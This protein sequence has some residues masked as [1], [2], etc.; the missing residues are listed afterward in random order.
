[1]ERLRLVLIALT[2]G[3]ALTGC[4]ETAQQAAPVIVLPVTTTSDEARAQF[5]SGLY[6]LDMARLID[7]RAYFEKA[8]EIDP[9]FAYA[10]LN[11]ANSANSLEEFTLNLGKAEEAASGVTREEQLLVEIARKGFEADLKGQLA[12]AQDLVEMAPESPRALLTLAGVQSLHNIHEEAR[13][14]IAR[15][16]ELAPTMAAAHMQAGNSYLFSEPRDLNKAEQHMHRAVE[17]A[18]REPIPP[19]LLGDVYRA[20]GQFEKARDAYTE[21]AKYSGD[22]GM[23]YQQRGHVNS[24]LGDYEAARAEYDESIAMARDNQAAIFGVYRAFVHVHAGDPTAA[25][26]ELKGLAA[27]IDNM[28][29][30]EPTGQKIFALGSAITIALHHRMVDEA[31]A[32][33]TDWSALMRAQAEQVGTDE[34]RRNRVSIIAYNEALLAIKQGRFDTAVEKANEIATLVEPDANPRK[35]EPVHEARGTIALEQGNYEEAAEHFRQGNYRNTIYIKYN[36][37][38]A[39]EG[40][41]QTDEA[42]ELYEDIANWGFNTVDLALTRKEAIEKTQK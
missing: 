14:S 39:L 21:A 40:A 23:P 8:T 6:A 20:Q 33:I 3:I 22:D 24:F 36:L 42:M 16:I 31:E 7:A 18:P 28:D 5:M 12:T 29:I 30:P 4:T 34:F 32:L 11:L 41:G 10:Y 27:R 19:D 9:A 26:E 37:A 15:A 35:M 13:Q 2:I 1:M 25:I 17:L 38:K